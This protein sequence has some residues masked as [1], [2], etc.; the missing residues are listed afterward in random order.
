MYPIGQLHSPDSMKSEEGLRPDAPLW[1]TC[2]H[3]D[4]QCA[5]SPT[6]TILVTTP[7]IGEPTQ[8]LPH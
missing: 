5:A 1:H 7:L 3:G 8:S 4:G 2:V 6:T